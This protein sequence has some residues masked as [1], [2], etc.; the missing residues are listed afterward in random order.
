MRLALGCH[1]AIVR[2]S[3][4]SHGGYVFATGGDGFAAAFARAGDGLAA[5]EEAQA[6]LA[7]AVWPPLAPI[8]VRM[9]LHT[10]EAT[11]RGGDYFGQAVNRAARVMAA[12][13]GGQ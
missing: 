11:E 10:G 4:E 1:D 8:K 7:A 12:G 13:H 9:G 5:A 3:V 6:R 2:A